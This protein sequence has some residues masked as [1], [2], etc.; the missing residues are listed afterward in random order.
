MQLGAQTVDARFGKV[1]Y[2]LKA[3]RT[4]SYEIG[5]S[6]RNKQ[7]SYNFVVFQNDIKDK[8]QQIN[9]NNRYY[10]FKN[11]NDARTKGAE[12]TVGYNITNAITTRLFWT[13]L[14]TEN[15]DSGK[16]LEFN[17]QRVLSLGFDVNITNN[18]NMGISATH[19]GEQYYTEGGQ[20]RT[21]DAYSLTNLTANYS[22]GDNNMFKVNAGINNV[23][24]T[25]VHKRLGS[26]VGAYYFAGLTV[27]F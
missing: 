8:I 7:F 2:D 20:D 15:K 12:L 25:K 14:R 3:E 10:T 13:E 22:F 23:L 9:V 5:L 6:G 17:P 26:N 19:I 21:T 27:K 4:L 16:R 1:A 18:L 11:I 24:N